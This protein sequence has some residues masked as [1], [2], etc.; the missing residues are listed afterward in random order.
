MTPLSALLVPIVLS[1]G[2]VFIVSSIIH[3]ATKWHKN[4]FRKLP[5]ED[6]V[7]SAL[8]PFAIPPGD[9]VAPMA[10]GMQDMKN[11]E[12]LAKRAQGPI[13]FATFYP[14]GPITMRASLVQ[15]F[16]FSLVVSLFAGYVAA[17]TL[18]PG[19][20][21]LSVFRVTGTVAFAGYVLALWPFTI[22]YKRNLGTTIRSSIDGLLYA[23]VTAGAFGWRWPAS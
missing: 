12:Y 7:L 2:F 1:G 23:L 15:W 4:D 18:P 16:I 22:W 9:Y 17:A 21:Y 3:M 11:P 19:S 6:A 8:R 5:N 14:P 10:S 20:P 13:L